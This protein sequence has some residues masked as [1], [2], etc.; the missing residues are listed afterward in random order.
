MLT[1]TIRD[2]SLVTVIVALLVAWSVDHFTQ[3]VASQRLQ[4][5]LDALTL[6][7]EQRGWS[8]DLSADHVRLFDRD[9]PANWTV[10]S[11][12]EYPHPSSSP[13]NH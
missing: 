2:I 7:L 11:T 8:V 1:F 9:S 10:R 3:S 6:M 12:D 5:Q 13:R 4:W